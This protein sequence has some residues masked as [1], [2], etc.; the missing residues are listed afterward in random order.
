MSMVRFFVFLVLYANSICSHAVPVYIN[1][2]YSQHDSGSGY[3]EFRITDPCVALPI[4]FSCDNNL[5]RVI[6]FDVNIPKVL[7]ISGREWERLFYHH[8]PG[9]KIISL[10]DGKGHSI[11]MKLSFTYTGYSVDNPFFFVGNSMQADGRSNCKLVDYHISTTG[12]RT[13][14][15]LYAIDPSSQKTGGLC[16]SLPFLY[17]SARSVTNIRRVFFGYKLNP[18]GVDTLPNGLYEGNLTLHIG[19]N[20][21]LDYTD[22][23]NQQPASVNFILRLVVRNQIKVLFPS[24]STRLKLNSDGNGWYNSVTPSLSGSIPMQVFSTVPISMKLMCQYLS[25]E[26]CLL[27]NL[28]NGKTMTLY[29]YRRSKG[30]ETLISPVSK[31]VFTMEQPSFSDLLFFKV[32]KQSVADVLDFPGTYSGNVTIIIDAVIN[33]VIN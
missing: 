2:E 31:T 20:K 7:D 3:S 8:F 4:S 17:S 28:S 11:N 27:K 1:A 29:V 30:R 24:G 25:K 19:S 12:T 32:G 22:M 6:A 5:S 13:D 16:F 14:T 26:N 9:E 33:P 10:S 18:V 21:D 23:P 15:I